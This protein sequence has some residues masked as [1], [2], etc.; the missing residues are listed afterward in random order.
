MLTADKIG[1]FVNAGTKL[2]IVYTG[3]GQN[4][5]S[6]ILS[7]GGA[8][9]YLTSAY[10]PYGMKESSEFIGEVPHKFTS[11]YMSY[12]MAVAATLKLNYLDAAWTKLA[13]AITA[14]LYKEGERAERVNEAYITVLRNGKGYT[15]HIVFDKNLINSRISY[16]GIRE[17][18]EKII[19][20]E[21][22]AGGNVIKHDHHKTTVA[23][24]E[25]RDSGTNRFFDI[26]T[27]LR[28]KP[29]P[30]AFYPGSFNP[31]HVGHK[32]LINRVEQKYKVPVILDIC[33]GHFHKAPVS[34]DEIFIRKRALEKEGCFVN[35]SDEKSFAISK[36]L[37]RL[38]DLYTPE[39]QPHY[40]IGGLDFIIKIMETFDADRETNIWMFRKF[41]F[42]IGARDVKKDM[43][44]YISFGINAKLREKVGH[45]VNIH[46]EYMD[47]PASSSEIRKE[48]TAKVHG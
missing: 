47:I 37:L 23:F 27:F 24:Y 29:Q 7:A 44:E 39:A 41:I 28:E 33:A 11:E 35:V 6:S 22:I 48:N 36:K 1:R 38:N 43:F 5:V 10:C 30:Y 46:W 9:N 14:T 15:K 17:I 2:I 18:E 42:I 26:P 12:K 34:N 20:D 8:S 4:F 31:I 32:E 19:T 21:I 45:D 13:V 16:N 3:G 40:V 25:G